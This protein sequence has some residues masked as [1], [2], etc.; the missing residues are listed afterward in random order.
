MLNHCSFALSY[1]S[2]S[3]HTIGSG[4]VTALI[5]MNLADLDSNAMI[6]NGVFPD[7]WRSVSNDQ[8]S[9]HESTDDAVAFDEFPVSKLEL[10]VADCSVASIVSPNIKAIDE[11][12]NSTQTVSR[13]PS[14]SNVSATTTSMSNDAILQEKFNLQ[15]IDPQKRYILL[16][17]HF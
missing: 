16:S 12:S 7:E 17:Y 4:S 11:D 8:F 5:T 9:F 13:R 1:L 10:E 3:G 15:K 6:T 14:T 2:H